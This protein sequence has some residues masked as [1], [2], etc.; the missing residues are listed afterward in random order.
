MYTKKVLF[1]CTTQM[2]TSWYSDTT[3]GVSER[4]SVD[5]S[6]DAASLREMPT[7][8]IDQSYESSG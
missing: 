4:I 8:G 6:V 2:F 7:T 5:S 1:A 3:T